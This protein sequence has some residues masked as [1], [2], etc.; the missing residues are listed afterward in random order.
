MRK[1]I[2][3]MSPNAVMGA[4]MI[5]PNQRNW[6]DTTAQMSFLDEDRDDDEGSSETLPGEAVG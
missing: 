4:E 1:E 3:H 2:I 6:T 5:L